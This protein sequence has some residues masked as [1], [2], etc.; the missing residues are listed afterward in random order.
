MLCQ[1]MCAF[2]SQGKCIPL[3]LTGSSVLELE[4][5]DTDD[6]FHTSGAN[7]F[8]WSLERMMLY[9]DV[10]QVDPSVN[11]SFSQHL[12]SG[13]S[14]PTPFMGCFNFQT[15]LA[16]SNAYAIIPI[17]RG[18]S[19]LVAIYFSFVVNGFPPCSWFQSPLNG[20]ISD[21]YNDNYQVSIQFGAEKIPTYD[22]MGVCANVLQIARNTGSARRQR[23]HV[24]DLSLLSSFPL[25]TRLF[26]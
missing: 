14:L 1:L 19:R 10:L 22:T 5:S 6:C 2:L 4:L 21:T 9:A 20:N 7:G 18:F 17:Q 15:S 25:H 26:T 8:T 16:S 23:L 13:E 11:N 12:L 24:A 3:S